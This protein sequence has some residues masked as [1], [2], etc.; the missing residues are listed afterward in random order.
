MRMCPSQANV[1][2]NRPAKA[3]WKGE[4]PNFTLKVFVRLYQHDPKRCD[5]RT[6]HIKLKSRRGRYVS[7]G[8]GLVT[9]RMVTSWSP[10]PS[11]LA[12]L[13]SLSEKSGIKKGD[14]EEE[15]GLL[16]LYF[17]EFTTKVKRI[18]VDVVQDQDLRVLKP[19]LADVRAV[20]YYE[21][22]VTT[23]QKY[24]IKTTCGRE[25]KKP[26]T[27]KKKKPA[28]KVTDQQTLSTGAET[29]SSNACPACIKTTKIPANFRSA[30]CNASAVY[31]AVAGRKGTRPI[32]LI[33]D[34]R[35]KKELVKLRKFVFYQ[36]PSGCNCS[37]FSKDGGRRWVIIVTAMKVFGHDLILDRNSIIMKRSK[38]VEK[39]V[40]AAQETCPREEE[41]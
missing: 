9:V 22:G 21:T 27:V 2:Y 41:E 26:V 29:S 11:Y 38:R 1:R 13:K 35:P 8:M 30:V 24:R 7:K 39:E 14:Y 6:L 32:K 40:R 19:K 16:H 25:A 20:E 34:L 36:L 31:K 3:Y 15:E 4:K 18:L 17:D 23:D 33:Q 28:T 10:T 12:Q 37:L 5:H